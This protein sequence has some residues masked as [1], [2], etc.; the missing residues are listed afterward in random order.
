MNIM[1]QQGAALVQRAS[2]KVA[3]FR[4]LHKRL[5]KKII[6]SGKGMSTLNNYMPCISHLAAAFFFAFL[7][8]WIWSR[9]KSTW[10]I[11]RRK[12]LPKPILNSRSLVSSSFSA[13]KV[14]ITNHYKSLCEAVKR[15]AASGHNAREL[16]QSSAF[17]G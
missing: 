7:F 15:L 16:L 14:W 10:C 9:L 6:V 2:A 17:W 13:L 8:T 4:T 3:R 5:E 1:K 12:V 11:S